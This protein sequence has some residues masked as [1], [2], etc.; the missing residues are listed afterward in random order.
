MTRPLL[1]S[2]AHGLDFLTFVLALSVFGISGE[3]N[4]AMTAVYAAGGL[5]A[6]LAL[7]TSGTVALACL[8]QMRSWALVPATGAG[9]LGALANLSALA[10]LGGTL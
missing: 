1:V 3:S 9:I 6:V 2:V 4:G 10:I 7:K 5:V 8:V